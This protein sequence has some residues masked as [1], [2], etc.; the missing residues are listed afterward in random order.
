MTTFNYKKWV[1]NYKQGKPLFEQ[2]TGTQ[3]GL[4]QSHM[5]LPIQ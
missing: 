2:T 3:G 5:L 1:T 4:W